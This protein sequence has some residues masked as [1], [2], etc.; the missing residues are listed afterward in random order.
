M[1]NQ[2]DKAWKEDILSEIKAAKEA[3]AQAREAVSVRYEAQDSFSSNIKKLLET[4]KNNP[5]MLRNIPYKLI[6]TFEIS[7]EGLT[8]FDKSGSIQVQEYIEDLKEFLALYNKS[9][10][11]EKKHGPYAV[12]KKTAIQLLKESRKS[13][14]MKQQ[15]LWT[16]AKN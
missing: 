11:R 14:G 6:H 3:I 9:Q 10:I 13:T 4:A 8:R 15:A 16:T 2:D 5:D 7:L 12:F 1:G